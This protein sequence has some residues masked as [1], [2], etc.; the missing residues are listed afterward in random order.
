MVF[1]GSFPHSLPIAPASKARHTGYSPKQEPSW[2]AKPGRLNCQLSCTMA[3]KLKTISAER[4]AEAPRNSEWI[5]QKSPGTFHLP[6]KWSKSNKLLNSGSSV[7]RLELW[8]GHRV[9]VLEKYTNWLSLLALTLVTKRAVR[10]MATMFVMEPG[11]QVLYPV[12]FCVHG[13]LFI[14]WAE[15]RRPVHLFTLLGRVSAGVPTS[16]RF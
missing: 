4:V 14:C 9:C 8:I 11:R 16:P 12:M 5:G 13:T 10:L 6:L 3:S 7:S 1:F 2:P 15:D